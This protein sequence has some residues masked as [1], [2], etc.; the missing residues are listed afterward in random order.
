MGDTGSILAAPSP[1]RGEQERGAAAV[2]CLE[3]RRSLW[4]PPLGMRGCRGGRRAMRSEGAAV[5]KAALGAGS[6]VPEL[7]PGLSSRCVLL[8]LLKYLS[9]AA[10]LL[11][12][13]LQ[14]IADQSS[15]LMSQPDC[16][17]KQLPG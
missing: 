9:H 12:C 7:K 5:P 17:H 4:E 14:L 13:Q 8:S 15:A 11:I 2:P 10:P 6:R 1:R 3:R 16:L